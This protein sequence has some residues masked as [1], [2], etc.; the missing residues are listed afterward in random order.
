VDFQKT[1][2]PLEDSRVYILTEN[3]M[4]DPPEIISVF[5]TKDAAEIA[6]KYYESR[7]LRYRFWYDIEEKEVL[8]QAP[9]SES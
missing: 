8:D 9:I 5:A 6:K 7:W 3:S 1:K 2:R 4:S